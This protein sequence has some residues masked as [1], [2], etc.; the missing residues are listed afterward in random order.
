MDITEIKP[1]QRVRVLQKVDRREGDWLGDVTG[2]VLEIS[3]AKTGSW[4]AHSHDNKL[5]LTRL[6]LQKPDGEITT[7]NIDQWTEIQVL[8]DGTATTGP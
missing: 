7:L 1:G 8:D 4:Y 6:K 2:S 3:R 5:W